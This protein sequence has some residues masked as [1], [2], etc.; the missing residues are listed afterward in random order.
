[1]ACSRPWSQPACPVSMRRRARYRPKGQ[2]VARRCLEFF[3]SR[4]PARETASDPRQAR[5]FHIQKPRSETKRPYDWLPV[6]RGLAP[7]VWA[8]PIG[9][10]AAQVL[11]D[12][13]CLLHGPWLE[14]AVLT[15]DS[16]SNAMKS[17]RRQS[18]SVRIH[19]YCMW[20]LL[21][22]H[23][24]WVP[25]HFR[26]FFVVSPPRRWRAAWPPHGRLAR[27]P[28]R[29][30]D[31]SRPPPPLCLSHERLYQ[32]Q[33]WLLEAPPPRRGRRGGRRRHP[34]RRPRA[35]RL[36]QRSCQRRRGRPRPRRQRR[37]RRHAGRGAQQWR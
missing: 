24:L 21:P 18:C 7:A 31:H 11:C 26:G 14:P 29:P 25:V 36:G 30:A 12:V 33:W 22:Q 23:L 3:E 15:T 20:A 28:A 17:R 4:W 2:G 27:P 13:A 35:P 10:P 9:L 8:D 1:M 6:A 16:E 19:T 5:P 34:P 37:P 32:R